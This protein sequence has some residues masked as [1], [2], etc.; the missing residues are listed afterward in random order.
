M[1]Q[2]QRSGW[3]SQRVVIKQTIQRTFS[4]TLLAIYSPSLSVQLCEITG[5]DLLSTE[6]FYCTSC[7]RQPDLPPFSFFLYHCWSKPPLGRDGYKWTLQTI[8]KILQKTGCKSNSFPD[9]MVVEQ[10]EKS[11]TLQ[12]KAIEETTVSGEKVGQLNTVGRKF[13]NSTLAS[14]YGREVIFQPRI[15][16]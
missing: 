12:T 7:S 6:E 10:E 14:T 16:W 5:I 9:P 4:M 13:R 11:W 8:Y 2:S 3:V 1:L 15:C